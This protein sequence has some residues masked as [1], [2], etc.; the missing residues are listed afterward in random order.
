MAH[1]NNDLMTAW[2][3]GNGTKI[4][5]NSYDDK[6]RVTKQVDG[7]G[8]VST[9][10]YSDGQTQTT[11]ANGTITTYYYDKQYRTT[12]IA[13]PD[14]TTISKAYDA[15]LLRTS[16]FTF[17]GKKE[18]SIKEIVQNTEG[19]YIYLGNDD[20]LI[21]IIFPSFVYSLISYD[22]SL[23][24]KRMLDIGKLAK[25]KNYDL[26]SE[27]G[28]VFEIENSK[29]VEFAQQNSCRYYEQIGIDLKDILVFTW[30]GAVEII[31]E[32]FPEIEVESIK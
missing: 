10:A 5:E 8:A 6:A 2:Y 7:T 28:Y 23:L 20:Y 32:V 25:K 13:Y 19:N 9:L 11:D 26:L 3:D 31:T 15:E 16:T 4:I 22:E 1:D 29:Y 17:P 14:Q 27:Y 30:N 12:K 21:K 18:Y 24:Q